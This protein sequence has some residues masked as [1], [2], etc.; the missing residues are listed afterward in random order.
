MRWRSL[1]RRRAAPSPT[2]DLT[3]VA[4]A[5]YV[6]GATS[7]TE[8][9]RARCK[10]ILQSPIA[11]QN[12][13]A[14]ELLAFGTDMDAAAAVR[15]LTEVGNLAEAQQRTGPDAGHYVQAAKS[16]NERKITP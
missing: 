3:A 2:P 10:A 7:A 14:A 13:P 4:E 8:C 16:I 1:F 15:L 12:R 5:A 11:D 6:H 9:E